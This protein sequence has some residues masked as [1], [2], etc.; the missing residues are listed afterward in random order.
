MERASDR[1]LG[2]LRGEILRGTLA[3]GDAVAS[4]RALSEQLA[5]NRQAVREAL[6]RLEQAGLVRITQGGP[7]R[8]LDWRD[9][10]GLEVLGDLAGVGDALPPDL[11]RSVVEMRASIGID[12]ARLCVQR[13]SRTARGR[14][15]ALAEEAAALVGTDQPAL[16][17]AYATMWRAVVEGSE[18]VAYRLAFNSLMRALGVHRAVADLV[19]PRDAD[20][21]RAFGAALEAGDAA[22]AA[23][24]AARL[25]A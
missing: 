2:E 19:L 22:A 7:T 12:A 4:E 1:V 14:A 21:I 23:A 11:V 6:K 9:A 3:P 20:A 25:L 17:E 13:A 5:V 18:N 10:A 16:E 15:G 8:V 24:G